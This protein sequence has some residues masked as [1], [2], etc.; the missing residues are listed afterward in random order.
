MANRSLNMPTFFLTTL[1]FV[2]NMLV[3]RKEKISVVMIVQDRIDIGG[4]N[5]GF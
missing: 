3:V 5:N 4:K 2:V 1:V